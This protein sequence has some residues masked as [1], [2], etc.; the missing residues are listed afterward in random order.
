MHWDAADDD[1]R[2]AAIPS[3]WLQNVFTLVTRSLASGLSAARLGRAGPAHKI[4]IANNNLKDI[5]S[6]SSKL[7]MTIGL[8][9]DFR[10][11]TGDWSW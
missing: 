7:F 6:V 2:L 5:F 10:P 11:F 4:V 8:I 9:A 1:E 3:N